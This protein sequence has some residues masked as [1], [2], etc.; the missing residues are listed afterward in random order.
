MPRL[1][2]NAS[3]P[4]S[5]A[6]VFYNP[7]MELSRDISVACIRAFADNRRDDSGLTYLDALAGCGIRGF[8]VANEA[9]FEVTVNDY[10]LAAYELIKRNAK[11][12]QQNVNVEHRDANALMSEARFNVIDVDPFGS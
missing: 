1:D 9:Q 6:S 4:P 7:R 3:Y 2:P 12:F 5:S 10:S 8:R 11:R